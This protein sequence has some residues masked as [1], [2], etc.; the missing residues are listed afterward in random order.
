MLLVWKSKYIAKVRIG[1]N[2]VFFDHTLL[3]N[4]FEAIV[5]SKG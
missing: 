2:V 3:D 1:N 5:N 4:L